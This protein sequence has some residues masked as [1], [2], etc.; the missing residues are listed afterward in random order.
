MLILCL[1]IAAG[2]IV[3]HLSSGT[4]GFDA[5]LARDYV[6]TQHAPDTSAENTVTA[7]YLNYRLWDTLFEALTLLVS[8]LAIR[9]LSWNTRTEDELEMPTAGGS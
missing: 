2:V 8:V 6:A 5:S 7:V 9:L 3:L 4:T 1:S